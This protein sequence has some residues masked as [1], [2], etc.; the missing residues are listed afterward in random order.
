MSRSIPLS[1]LSA[2]V[3]LLAALGAAAQDAPQ[4]AAAPLPQSVWDFAAWKLD[5]VT[6]R[7]G[8]TLEG[9]IERETERQIRLLEIRRPEGRGMFGV[10]R[11]LAKAE[12]AEIQRLEPAQR[13]QSRERFDQFVNRGRLEALRLDNLPLEEFKEARQSGWRY[14]GKW[15]TLE[16]H[17]S[18]ELTRVFIGRLEEAFTAYLRVLP[19][20]VARREELRIMVFG[21]SEA[22]QALA[23]SLG[24]PV[25][26]A[27]FY[28]PPHNLVAAGSDLSRL[29]G[30]L[31]Q[32]QTQ[33]AAARAELNRLKNSLPQRVE[34]QRALLAKTV[35]SENARRTALTKFRR[36]IEL[37]I[38]RA[39]KQLD[40]V[41]RANEAAL[42]QHAGRTLALLRHEA[43][44]AYLENYVY[45]QGRYDVPR[46]LNEG[47]AQI[48][49]NGLLESDTFRVDVPSKSALAELADESA[50]TISLIKVLAADHRNFLVPH[51]ER[52]NQ[53]HYACA[54]GLAYYLTFVRPTLGTPAAH[55]YVSS[56]A[57]SLDPI[58]RFE[59]L[60]DQPLSEFEAQWRGWL[61][62]QPG[63]GR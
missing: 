41:D 6:L 24:A 45:P 38:Q 13:Q 43:F 40:D 49:E 63:V 14:R 44:H 30:Q 51:G 15:F 31:Q 23:R 25:Q 47:L 29:A 27:A 59:R 7:S 12:I 52:G 22:Y 48:F 61:K 58:A 46:W 35:S 16:S 21:T 60:V 55:E 4:R 1:G 50:E 26:N 53:A 39:Q 11:P 56:E 36:Q 62:S 54:W 8:E 20:R 37:E 18:Q 5:R 2:P 9:L 3:L 32:A 57:A 34:E 10:S 19:P 17:A 33:H 42:Q 28:H